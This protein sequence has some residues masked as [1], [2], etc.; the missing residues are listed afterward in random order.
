M[1]ASLVR[2]YWNWCGK[3]G[4]QTVFKYRS[5]SLVWK[6]GIVGGELVAEGKSV[7]NP[8]ARSGM[9]HL[10]YCFF[11][12]VDVCHLMKH[13]SQVRRCA[14]EWGKV[15]QT[16]NGKVWMKWNRLKVCRRGMLCNQSYIYQYWGSWWTKPWSTQDN[17]KT[18]RYTSFTYLP[19]HKI[20]QD[21]HM[22]NAV[23][24]IA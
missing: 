8:N 18:S 21:I 4:G 24:I 5:C 13:G 17:N 14:N 19:Y 10:G 6:E 11:E 12:W 9:N 20:F 3:N 15:N 2:A 16:S 23:H 1:G 7:Q 22:W